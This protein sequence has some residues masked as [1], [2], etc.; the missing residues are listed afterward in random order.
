M[1]QRWRWSVTC[2]TCGLDSI[3]A[4]VVRD[5][6]EELPEPASLRLLPLGRVE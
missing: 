4:R 3:Q 6:L 5:Y 1:L 2:V